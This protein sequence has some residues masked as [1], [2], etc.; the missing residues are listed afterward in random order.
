VAALL[1]AAFVSRALVPVGFM[2]GPGGLTLCSG[3][4]A[5]ETGHGMS[6]MDMPGMDMSGMDMSAK[7]GHPGQPG[8]GPDHGSMGIC[9]FAAAATAMATIQQASPVASLAP[10]VSANVHLPPQPFISRG[11]IVPTRLPRGPPIQIA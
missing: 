3:Y 7:A 6:G 9:P 2:P 11:T 10:F 1:L 8:Q 5:V 4:A